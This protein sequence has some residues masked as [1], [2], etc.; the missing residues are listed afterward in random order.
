[1]KKQFCLVLQGNIEYY[2]GEVELNAKF[3]TFAKNANLVFCG[4]NT[5]AAQLKINSKRG[6]FSF[7]L[8]FF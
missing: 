7:A 8:F 3:R 2:S 4:H 5:V 6:E 1:M